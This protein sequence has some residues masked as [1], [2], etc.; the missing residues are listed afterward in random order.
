MPLR[1]A[2]EEYFTAYDD[3]Q[4]LESFHALAHDDDL[5]GAVQGGPRGDGIPPSAQ[6]GAARLPERTRGEHSAAPGL[7]E[8]PGQSA[9]DRGLDTARRLPDEA[10][11]ARDPARLSP[12]RRASLGVQPRPGKPPGR[13]AQRDA[14]PA[15]VGHE[16]LLRRRRAA[17]HGAHGPRVAAQRH[18]PHAAVGR[19]PLPVR[20][21][22][23]LGP[24]PGAA[25][26]PARAGRRS[27]RAGSRT[28]S[29]TTG[30]T[31][32][33]RSCH[34]TAPRS[35]RSSPT[36]SS[37]RRRCVYEHWRKLRHEGEAPGRGR[38]D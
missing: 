18:R 38:P 2:D 21:G 12:A 20:G 19:L 15:H 37:S 33:S 7:L 30:A 4:R 8:Q 16:R 28:S 29:S 6:G 27:T 5:L 11:H 25:F 34:T 31:S 32:T 17:V 13:R 24:R 22:A 35:R 1:E 9:A 14:R 26:R 3:L 23:G 10:G 36:S